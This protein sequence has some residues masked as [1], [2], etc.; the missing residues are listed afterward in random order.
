MAPPTSI[1]NDIYE[2]LGD[3]WYT[4]QDDPVALLRA[5]SR[6]KT[7]WILERMPS[8][9]RVLDVGCGAGFLS[10]SLAQAGHSVTGLDLSKESLRVAREHD[11]T[12]SVD[13]IAGDAYHLPFADASFDAVS[14]M[15]FLEHIERPADFIREVSRVLKPG[16]RFFFHTFNRNHF[17]HFVIIKMVEWLVAN[18]PKHMHVIELFLKPSEVAAMCASS[19]IDV[20]EMIGIKPIFSTIT[21][22]DLFKRQVPKGFAFQFTKSLKLSYL[23]YGTK[24]PN[25]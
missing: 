11:A 5:E 3:R 17:S 14:A 6:L 4:A 23:G 16:G 15:D 7:P 19:K 10:N 18:T 25:H 24:S 2:Q 8:G 20:V 22:R 9:A 13:Y 21:L 12:G 1:N